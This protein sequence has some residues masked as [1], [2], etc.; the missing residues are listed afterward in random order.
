[1]SDLLFNNMLMEHQIKSANNLQFRYVVG[2]RNDMDYK[3]L[4]E[5]IDPAVYIIAV[6]SSTIPISWADVV[7]QAKNGKLIFHKVGISNTNSDP[8]FYD[9]KAGVKSRPMKKTSLFSR[10][11]RYVHPSNESEYLLLQ[12]H[13]GL[14]DTAIAIINCVKDYTEETRGQIVHKYEQEV[15]GM[16]VDNFGYHPVGSRREGSVNRYIQENSLSNLRRLEI[17]EEKENGFGTLE[18]FFGSDG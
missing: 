15:L 8:T 10:M 17:R 5:E 1:M 14:G 12:E 6:T 4:R 2:L 3:I 9:F 11:Q 16:I 18:Q 13:I 7:E